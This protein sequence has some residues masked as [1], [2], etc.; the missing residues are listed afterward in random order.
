MPIGRMGQTTPEEF[1]G[2]LLAFIEEG[3]VVPVVGPELHTI[4]VGGHEQPLYRALAERLLNKYGFEASDAEAPADGR[5]VLRKHL[6]L[7]DA[8]IGLSQ[9][10][11][12]IVDL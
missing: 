3:R 10:G 6:E 11:L 5:V 12:V 8:V 7:N 1:W 2:D 9:R 4:A